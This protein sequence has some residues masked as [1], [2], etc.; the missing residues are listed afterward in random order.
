MYRFLQEFYLKPA[1]V[2][3]VARGKNIWRKKWEILLI[4]LF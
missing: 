4:D 1:E 2:P 3:G